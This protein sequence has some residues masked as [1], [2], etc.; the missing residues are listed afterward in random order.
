[1]TDG[2][3]IVGFTC[4]VMAILGPILWSTWKDDD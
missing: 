4:G 3:I 1:M 2:I